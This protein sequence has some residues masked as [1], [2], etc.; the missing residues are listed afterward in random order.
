MKCT[1]CKQGRLLP[2]FIEGQFRAHQCDQCEGQW[3]YIEDFVTWQE[4]NPDFEFKSEDHYEVDD[5]KQA[6]L[7]PV[8]GTLMQ[9][10]RYSKDTAHKLDY[11]ASVGG[12]WLD[13]GEWAYLKE[14]GIA[15][16]INKI[17]TE[18]WQKQLREG[19]AQATFADLYRSKFGSEDYE[20]AKAIRSWLID[21][22]AKAELRA[23]LMAQD[24]YSTD[25]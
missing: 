17:F 7:C 19:H 6:L 18:Q 11:S 21:H 12:V 20:K 8:T 4:T 2:T 14:F 23:Y 25:R 1:Y 3:L 22:P 15:G 9:K 16:C 10:F 24:P 5:T 13:K